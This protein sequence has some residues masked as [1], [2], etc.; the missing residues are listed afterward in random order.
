MIPPVTA[1]VIRGANL[2]ALTR[3]ARL[4]GAHN[5]CD[6]PSGGQFGPWRHDVICVGDG[7]RWY[8]IGQLGS[9]VSQ[10]CSTVWPL[11]HC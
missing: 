7:S 8:W 2:L 9:A 5:R 11:W 10:V 1:G 3:R 6:C 4:H